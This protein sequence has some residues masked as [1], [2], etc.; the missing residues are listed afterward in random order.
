M[1][2]TTK[3]NKLNP[4]IRRQRFWA[5]SGN[6]YTMANV[7]SLEPQFLARLLRNLTVT[8]VDSIELVV[9]ICVQ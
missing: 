3:V 1:L 2:L 4:R 6:L 7:V 5:V 8:N 9:R